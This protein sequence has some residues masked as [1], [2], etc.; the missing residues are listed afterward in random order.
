MRRIFAQLSGFLTWLFTNH[1][2]IDDIIA[3][4][5]KKVLEMYCNLQSPITDIFEPI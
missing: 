4:E 5:A 3:E 2:D 1:G